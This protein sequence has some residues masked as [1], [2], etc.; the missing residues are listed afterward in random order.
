MTLRSKDLGVSLTLYTKVSGLCP[1]YEVYSVIRADI[2]SV[3]VNYKGYYNIL[4]L[5]YQ[6]K[7][8]P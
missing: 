5:F 4:L 6:Y 8:I 2:L 3:A 7:Y 1:L